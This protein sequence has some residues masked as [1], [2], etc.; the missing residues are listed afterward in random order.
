MEEYYCPNYKCHNCEHYGSFPNYCQKRIDHKTIEFAVPWFVSCP[1]YNGH[2][3]SDF[4]PSLIHVYD[5]Q[6]YWTNWESYWAD[7]LENWFPYYPKEKPED[8][9]IYFTLNGDK[10]I[11]Y[12]VNL[13]DYIN[14]SMIDG[15]RLKAVEKMYYKRTKDGFGYKLVREKIEGVEL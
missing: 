11:R 4:K 3:C 9:L 10:E 13:M 12:G 5:L 6:N 1:S 8:K 7:Y 2:I 15:N 14:N